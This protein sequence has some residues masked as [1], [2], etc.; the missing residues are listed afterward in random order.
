MSNK[1]DYYE[2]LEISKQAS[3]TEIKA[4][5]RKMAM[6]YHPDRNQGNKEAEDKFKEAAEAY[7]ILSD[8][9]KK[10]RY[11]QFGHAGMRGTGFD[12]GFG[13]VN[14]IFSHFSDIFGGGSIFDEIFG[15]GG[16]RRHSTR[17]N[18]QG[19]QG[20]DLKVNLRL[21]LEEISD[22]TEK[23][24]KVKRYE[25]CKTCSGSG[26]KNSSSAAVCSTCNGSGEI[27]N[28][29]RSM[30]G[31]FV[32]IQV[33]HTC[34]GEGRVIKD[35]CPVCS[36]EGREKKESVIKVNIP[37]GVSSGNYIPLRGEG[38][39]G[40]RGG[41]NGDLIVLIEEITHKYFLR[42][43]DDIHYEHTIS[44]PQAVLGTEEEIPVLGGTVMLK[45]D[46]GT[47]P[48]KILRL[49]DKGIKHLNHNGRGDQLV[50]INIHIPTKLSGKE[51]EIFKELLHSE[52]FK[53]KN[54]DG[55]TG[56]KSFFGKVKDSFS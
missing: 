6:K 12:Q 30:F 10:A 4:A 49:R 47:Q 41:H 54:K 52:H 37:A 42:D 27:R 18:Q 8:P 39:A 48:G 34:N 35:K 43:Q 25:K 51:K 20:N 38:D 1:R 53:A 29:S 7:E 17:H 15:S 3:D 14:D 2:I 13:N 21:T 5:Y 46:A 45:I 32:N 19:I 26:A 40:I 24:I 11:D 31:Q 16:S 44:I 55:N 22:G 36:G 28:V 50:H 23:T 9:N 56:S 33:C